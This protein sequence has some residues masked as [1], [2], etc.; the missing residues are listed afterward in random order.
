MCGIAAIIRA[1]RRAKQQQQLA[2]PTADSVISTDSAVANTNNAGCS[3]PQQQQQDQQSAAAAAMSNETLRR[4]LLALAKRGP[5]SLGVVGNIVIEPN[6]CG[7]PSSSSSTSSSSPQSVVVPFYGPTPSVI[8]DLIFYDPAEEGP[9]AKKVPLPLAIARGDSTAT[10]AA[11]SKSSSDDDDDASPHQSS[12][13]ATAT[14]VGAVLHLRGI[15]EPV[16]QPYNGQAATSLASAAAGGV[17]RSYFC[18]NGEVFGGSAS[19]NQYTSDTSVVYATLRDIEAEVA[20]GA[21]VGEEGKTVTEATIEGNSGEESKKPYYYGRNYSVRQLQQV[22]LDRVRGVFEAHVYEGPFAFVYHASSLGGLTVFGRD[23]VGR[24]SL[25]VRAKA[26]GGCDGSSSFSGEFIVSSVACQEDTCSS[27]ANIASS[28]GSAPSSVVPEA[29]ADAAGNR[30]AVSQSVQREALRWFPI[31]GQWAE[32]PTTGLFGVAV[33]DSD[34]CIDTLTAE[35]DPSSLFDVLASPWAFENR[36]HPLLTFMPPVVSNNGNSSSSD[37]SDEAEPQ[38]PLPAIDDFIVK[39][40]EG[41][42]TA[43]PAAAVVAAPRNPKAANTM[44]RLTLPNHKVFS[45]YPFPLRK[46]VAAQEGA[47]PETEIVRTG[48]REGLVP[49]H[50]KKEESG[51]EKSSTDTDNA[52]SGA[53]VVAASPSSAA[54]PPQHFYGLPSLASR[55]LLLD[56]MTRFPMPIIDMAAKIISV[57]G[58]TLDPRI[59]SPFVASHLYYTALQDAVCR[60]VEASTRE[61]S[62]ASNAAAGAGNGLSSGRGGGGGGSGGVMVMLSGGIDSTVLAAL[63][64]YALPHSVPIE[65]V[66][67]AF[68]DKCNDV[69]SSLTPD[70]IASYQ[71]FAELLNLP[72]AAKRRW[73]FVEVNVCPHRLRRHKRRVLSLVGPRSTVMDHDIGCA[74]W[75]AAQ[76]VG[77]EIPCE[78]VLFRARYFAAKDSASCAVGTAG[79][80]AGCGVGLCDGSIGGGGGITN[81]LV[82]RAALPPTAAPPAVVGA[83][84]SRSPTATDEKKTEEESAVAKAVVVEETP[85]EAIRRRYGTLIAVLQSEGFEPRPEETNDGGKASSAPSAASLSADPSRM[86][87]MPP[88]GGGASS[89]DY[90]RGDDHHLLPMAGHHFAG[91]KSRVGG[92]LGY[93]DTDD[94]TDG[95]KV[96][97]ENND[98]AGGIDPSLMPRRVMLATLGKEYSGCLTPIWRDALG[99]KKLGFYL[100][101]AARD[102]VIATGAVGGSA[103][104][105]YVQLK[106]RADIA[107]A[108][109][110]IAERRRVCESPDAAPYTCQSPIVIMGMGADETLGGYVRHERLAAQHG[111][112]G[113]RRELQSD[114]ERLWERNLGRD[115]RVISDSGREA[116][117]PFIDERVL[118]AVSVLGAA[119]PTAV[120]EF[121]GAVPPNPFANA[122]ATAHSFCHGPTGSGIGD[123]KVLRT[124]ARMIGLT[125]VSTLQK[126]AVQFGSRI[127]DPKQ[128][129]S[130][131]LGAE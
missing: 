130:A 118:F 67:V 71:A 47:V 41:T 123:K 127:A 52:T 42:A 24:R 11:N 60:R 84:R 39:K 56:A 93:D 28:S 105:Q 19:F 109:A 86:C 58:Y 1:T 101:D 98:D 4:Q 14:F 88:M 9:T 102:G 29:E 33:R 85:E 20:G 111:W 129:G 115:D 53:L 49:L 3:Q 62:A 6:T 44:W 38:Y 81:K 106:R 36:T 96:N 46:L 97:D 110:T 54:E 63:T 87:Q 22:F 77:V 64:H 15:G 95:P 25:V 66:N 34:G 91:N 113:L 70:R 35:A 122:S 69:E 50:M 99:Y 51:E 80:V 103:S 114:F 5:T 126:R 116:R 94:T 131:A 117:F 27:N 128:R 10:G 37:A 45:F 74:L 2:S 89:Y 48:A 26:A 90:C 75:F 18:W 72:S 55:Q 8:R 120:C 43:D 30:S 61:G 76:G 17:S 73:R 13:S 57:V 23:P 119:A 68:V 83:K 59:D 121:K 92:A 112:A 108:A 124:V 7:A 12:V 21:T 125:G 104:A 65:V 79:G 82:R 31:D 78:D 40:E 100:S 32:V 16:R 107:A